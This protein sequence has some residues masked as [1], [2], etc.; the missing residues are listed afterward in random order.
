MKGKLI[1]KKDF[2]VQMRMRMAFGEGQAPVLSG[3]RLILVFDHEGDSFMVVLDKNT[4][5]EIW[6]ADRDEPSNWLL[7]WLLN[8]AGS[9]R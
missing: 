3:D 4:G 2:G 9:S 1:W 7:R 6:R 5:K 8:T